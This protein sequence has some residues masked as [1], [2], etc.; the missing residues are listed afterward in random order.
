[1]AQSLIETK[2]SLLTVI[3]EYK[4]GKEQNQCLM[5]KSIKPIKSFR[6]KKSLKSLG[7]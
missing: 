6:I 7:S 2:F 4:T 5:M 1:M 3:P